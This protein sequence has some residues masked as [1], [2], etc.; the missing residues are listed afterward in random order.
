M[1]RLAHIN[2]RA[3]LLDATHWFDLAGVTGDQSLAD[4]MVAIARHAEL[5]IAHDAL[6]SATPG[7]AIAEARLGACVPRPEKVFAIGLNYRSHA[8][9]SGMAIPP[10]P[11]RERI[12]Y[13]PSVV[14]AGSAICS[15]PL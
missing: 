12:S 14:P 11:M 13:G 4:P 6:A 10:A 1:F 9:E 3:A 2:G 5:H 15:A 7:G 8:E